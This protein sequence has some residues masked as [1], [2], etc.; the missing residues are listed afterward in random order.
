MYLGMR[1]IN[2]FVSYVRKFGKST[3]GA[4]SWF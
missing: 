1:S 4:C 2:V 3:D